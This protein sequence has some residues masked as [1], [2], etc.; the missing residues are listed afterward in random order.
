M[1]RRRKAAGAPPCEG[2]Q[3]DEHRLNPPG[4]VI[5]ARVVVRVAGEVTNQDKN[6]CRACHKVVAS[7]LDGL[8]GGI[9]ILKTY[10]GGEG[11]TSMVSGLP[12]PR[13]EMQP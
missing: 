8:V 4:A 6:L 12:S 1:F 5:Q 7:G 2:F 10:S 11:V 3:D 13:K 9:T